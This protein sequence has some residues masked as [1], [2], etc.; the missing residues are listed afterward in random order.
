MSETPPIPQD[1]APPPEPPA[2]DPSPDEVERVPSGPVEADPILIDCPVTALGYDG[3]ECFWFLGST[4]LVA[5]RKAADFSANK[6]L[7]LF[8]GDM[9]WLTKY[10]LIDSGRRGGSDGKTPWDNPKVTS[11]LMRACRREG[12]FDPATIRGPG[13]WLEDGKAGP[14][15]GGSLVLHLGDRLL[16]V[17]FDDKGRPETTWSKAGVQINGYVYPRSAPEMAPAETDPGTGPGQDLEAFARTFAFREGPADA[18]LLVGAVACALLAGAVPYRPPVLI[19]GPS[20]VGKT[21]L[22]RLLRGI[23]ERWALYFDD[24]TAAA[25]RA[26]LGS[27]ARPVIL[28]EFEMETKNNQ[29]AELLKAIRYAATRGGGTWARRGADAGK[30]RTEAQFFMSSIEPPPVLGQD[31]NRRVVL[32]LEPRDRKAEDAVAFEDR[33]AVMAV[34]GPALL[35]RV[36]GQWARW[37]E[38]F[39]AYRRALILNGHDTRGADTFGVLLAAADLLCEEGPAE[40]R[41]PAWGEILS[42]AA[43][44]ERDDVR[45]PEWDCWNHL[46]GRRLNIGLGQ[47]VPIGTLLARVVYSSKEHGLTH[48]KLRE[49]GIGVIERDGLM[50][51]AVHNQ[52]AALEDFYRGTRWE[53]GGWATQLRRLTSPKD[54]MKARASKNGI[55]LASVQTR[56][57]LVPTSIVEHERSDISD[58]TQADHEAEEAAARAPAEGEIPI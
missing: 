42:A 48:A 55:T 51:V 15:A 43:F 38:T 2:G 47:D 28:D 19:T 5:L 33:L 57:S 45:K 35:R 25:V 44:A 10:H 31:A 12:V 13:V 30:G 50:W 6:V 7:A 58:G 52:H 22:V 26:D 20:G 39:Q 40:G 54:G 41:A 56:A 9:D 18:R 24:I 1:D 14:L 29:T 53:G 37:A 11:L 27:A 17:D 16:R 49:H 8:M 21:A 36:I 3:D 32:E 46:L 4:G 23:L 34:L